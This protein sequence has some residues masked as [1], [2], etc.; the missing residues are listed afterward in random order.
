MAGN[1]EGVGDRAGD[2]ATARHWLVSGR[3]QGVGYRWWL[4]ERARAA[5][6]RGWVRNLAAGR[7]EAVVAGSPD[8]VERLA[9]EARR[10][11]AA[12][13]VDGLES[14]DWAGQVGTG[15]FEQADT[16]ARP[17]EP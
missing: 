7:V 15:G 11:P 8:A 17:A 5:G 3:V 1:E 10:G 12:A 16:A 9:A 4:R 6:L 13:R 14:A 2:G